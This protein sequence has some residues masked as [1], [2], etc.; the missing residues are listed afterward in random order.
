MGYL[1]ADIR[2]PK[3]IVGSELVRTVLDFD[4]PSR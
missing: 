2:A 3:A 1:D 4:E